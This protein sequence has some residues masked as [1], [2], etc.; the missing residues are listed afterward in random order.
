MENLRKI[1]IV[2][3]MKVGDSADF[4]FESSIMRSCF[5]YSGNHWKSDSKKEFTRKS[6]DQ[7]GEF[8]AIIERVK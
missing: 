5:L 6:Y 7:N 2:R 1:H 8:R 3:N 4:I